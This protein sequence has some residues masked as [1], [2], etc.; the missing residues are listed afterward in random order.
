MIWEPALNGF[1]YFLHLFSHFR[2]PMQFDNGYFALRN[3]LIACHRF[4]E[5]SRRRYFAADSVRPL[6]KEERL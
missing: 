4:A 2:P 3:F 1:E 5:I 6:A